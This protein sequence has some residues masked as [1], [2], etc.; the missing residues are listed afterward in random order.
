MRLSS[1]PA[2]VAGI[3][4]CRCSGARVRRSRGLHASCGTVRPSLHQEP[5]L[6]RAECIA[7]EEGRHDQHAG[8][9]T[10]G[11]IGPSPLLCVRPH[12][13]RTGDAARW[14]GR[15]D[16][17][18]RIPR[19]R[20]TAQRRHASGSPSFRA[21]SASRTGSGRLSQGANS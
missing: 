17:P 4:H 1:L 14:P 7:G 13:K 19:L 11:M 10:L 18:G 12:P 20:R 9:A 15:Y 2:A 8:V 3:D 6:A 21:T 16:L 5:P